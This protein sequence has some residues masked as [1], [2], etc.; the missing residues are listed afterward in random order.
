VANNT[1]YKTMYSFSHSV[2]RSEVG[3]A[4][5]RKRNA[6]LAYEFTT[7]IDTGM[8]ENRLHQ[9]QRKEVKQKQA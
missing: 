5:E 9:K 8:M 2:N 6:A 1:K 4:L 7:A 3:T